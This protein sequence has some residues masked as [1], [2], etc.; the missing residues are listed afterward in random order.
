[1]KRHHT[2]TN[3][4]IMITP[5]SINKIID[6]PE[7]YKMLEIVPFQLIESFPYA[8][9]QPVG[10]EC[11][12]AIIDTETT[13]FDAT[14]EEIIEFGWVKVAYS[15][16]ADTITSLLECGTM[17]QE[18]SKPIPEIITEITGITDDMVKGLSFDLAKVKNVLTEG[19]YAVI[20]HNKE[21]DK[22]FID[23][24]FGATLAGCSITWGCSVNDIDWKSRR[25]P[26]K[27][28][29]VLLLKSGYWYKAHRA[30]DDVIALAW[31]LN[32]TKGAMNELYSAIN[33]QYVRVKAVNSPFEVKD[34]LKSQ[35]FKWN[36]DAKVWIIEIAEKDLDGLLDSM[37][38]L[39]QYASQSAVIE[40]LSTNTQ[41]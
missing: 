1:M 12:I 38:E 11:T 18:P 26:S 7:H 28:L 40:H 3:E 34:Q 29:E 37:N 41:Y 13:G 14:V 27:S 10:D 35:G 5:D 33:T 30:I 4:R 15:P 9:S 17:Y 16:S 31:V 20:A 22:K 21:F 32:I 23:N 8:L 36:N 19:T 6:N 2:K 39:Y 25:F 24:T